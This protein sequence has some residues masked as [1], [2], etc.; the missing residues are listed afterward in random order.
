M[1]A[2]YVLSGRF[3]QASLKLVWKSAA[4][5]CLRQTRCLAC[6]DAVRHP[7]ADKPVADRLVQDL[8]F[9]CSQG[10]ERG[11]CAHARSASCAGRIRADRFKPVDYETVRFGR[12]DSGTVGTSPQASQR[13]RRHGQPWLAEIATRSNRL[14]INSA[15]FAIRC[16]SST[17]QREL[18]GRTDQNPDAITRTGEPPSAA[19]AMEV[20]TSVLYLQAAFEELMPQMT[21]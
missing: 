3:V 17:G 14:Q 7:A 5:R 15:W 11:W 19:L 21:R 8:L 16:A 13:L 4:A 20:A 1:T 2:R 18:G 12:F 6:A 10:S 9:F